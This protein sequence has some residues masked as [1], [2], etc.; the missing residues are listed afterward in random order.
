MDPEIV[1]I[2]ISDNDL[3]NILEKELT[4]KKYNV[5]I[6]K[7]EQEII[8]F[9]ALKKP[10][11]LIL[12]TSLNESGLRAELAVKVKKILDLP[13]IFLSDSPE[14]KIFEQARLINPA[15]FFSKPFDIKNIVRA[16]D[17]GISD[18]RFHKEIAD[19]KS[20]YELIIKA[21][22]S[23]VYEIDPAAFEIDGDEQLAEL[24][25][26]TK[27][28]VKELGWASLMPIEDYNK[29]KELLNNLLQGKI[30][31][32][33]IEHR[34][35]KKNGGIA[36][37]VS[38]GS[39]SKDFD[40]KIKIVGTLSDI[41]ERKNAEEKLKKYSEE[42]KQ[43]NS[44]KDKFFSIIS[45]DLRNPFNSLLGFSELLAN[46][47]EDLTEQEIKDSAKSLNRTANHLF[48]LLTN[49][50]EWSRLQTGN[51]SMEK[52][53]FSLSTIINYILD[54]YSSPISEKKINIIKETNCEINLFADRNMV[55]AAI[56][57]IIFNAIK[58]SNIGG[59]V[60]VGC[61]TNDNKAEVY[62]EDNGVGIAI[63]D[64]ERLFKIDRQFSTEGTNCEKGTGFGLLLAKELLGKNDGSIKFTSTINVGSTFIIS[65]P[66]TK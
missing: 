27:A 19:I 48:N 55:E 46:N 43:S 40:G 66:L 32:Y 37:A 14:E 21:A 24:F 8:D 63:E 45:H 38:C 26:Y 56:R 18:H 30:E 6:A 20:K 31:S 29:K 35:I 41:T 58:Y 61:R 13:I 33:S 54:V 36:W 49:L 12:D 2:A 39:L 60:K 11:I 5:L 4:A 51:F 50:L 47:I 17:L 44:A 64:Q 62:V 28:E 52:T 3:I 42:L 7:P 65:L 34:V 53:D 16:I 57:N 25:G 1:L 15:A 22:N 23:G 10:S 59:T 9:I